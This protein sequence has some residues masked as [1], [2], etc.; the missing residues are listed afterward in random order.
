MRTGDLTGEIPEEILGLGF[1]FV[2][3][4]KILGFEVSNSQ[5]WDKN[6]FG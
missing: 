4:V 5:E 1:K 3:K 6:N 2:E